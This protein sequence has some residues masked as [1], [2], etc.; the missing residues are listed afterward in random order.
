[1]A[2]DLAAAP[3]Y[4]MKM[5]AVPGPTSPLKKNWMFPGSWP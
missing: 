5:A 2:A 3:R 1:M 4:R